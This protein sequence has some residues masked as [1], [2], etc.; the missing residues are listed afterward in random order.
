[1][2]GGCAL[3][4]LLLAGAAAPAA[5]LT[6]SLRDSLG[7]S[8]DDR[9]AVPME[10]RFRP[11]AGTPFVVDLAADQS[12]LVRFDSS[13]EIWV[14]RPHAGP[15][16]D[17]IYKN[18]VGEP[19]LRATRVGG[20]TLFTPNNPGGVAA[21]FAG[22]APGLRPP[23][24]STPGD[25]LRAFTQASARAGRATQQVISF[26]ARDVPLAAA[27]FFADAAQVVAEAFMRVASRADSATRG[28]GRWSKVEFFVGRTPSVSA[29]AGD[30]RVTL[31]PERGFAGRPSS[32]RI[33]GVI[34][35]ARPAP[36]PPR[37]PPLA[38][39]RA[40]QRR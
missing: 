23:T 9:F 17:V 34:A 31:A 13:P 28:I 37:R 21:A 27:P 1:M 12:L 38:T 3:A 16:G 39:Q 40:Q 30:L 26:E 8:A 2:S 5:A 33:A 11:D 10:G 32:E 25:L 20:L 22:D 29:G 14:L 6:A 7:A 18:D 19:V 35:R 36:P 4:A 24:V 15:R